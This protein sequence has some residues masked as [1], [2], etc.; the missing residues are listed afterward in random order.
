MAQLVAEEMGFGPG[1]NSPSYTCLFLLNFNW[2]LKIYCDV[3]HC[4]M[5]VNHC[6]QMALLVAEEM[7]FG[8]GWNSPSHTSLAITVA[9]Q[10]KLANFLTNSDNLNQ[11]WFKM[12]D[13][14]N[15]DKLNHWNRSMPRNINWLGIPNDLSASAADW[16]LGEVCSSNLQPPFSIF[17]LKK[18]KITVRD[19]KHRRRWRRDLTKVDFLWTK[20]REQSKAT[21]NLFGELDDKSFSRHHLNQINIL[22]HK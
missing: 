8:Q 15:L 5:N 10:F 13:P 11:F 3:S 19:H 14:Y 7:G 22:N 9:V 17:F 1:W 6:C 16:G 12:P 18:K 2:K 20:W 4:H 21:Y